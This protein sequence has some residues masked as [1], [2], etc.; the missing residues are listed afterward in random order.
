MIRI[1][2]AEATLA[3]LVDYAKTAGWPEGELEE[4][5]EFHADSM[6]AWRHEDLLWGFQEAFRRRESRRDA[7]GFGFNL[8]ACRAYSISGFSLGGRKPVSAWPNPPEDWD[9]GRN[10]R[11][12]YALGFAEMMLSLLWYRETGEFN[13]PA[14]PDWSRQ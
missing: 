14:E 7:L 4:W 6:N 1:D 3:A 11:R 13:V 2:T 10:M 12:G 5:A 9:Y 8:G